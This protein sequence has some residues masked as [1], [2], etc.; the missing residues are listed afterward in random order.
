MLVDDNQTDNY[1]H[2]REIKKTKLAITI[3][4]KSSGLEALEYLKSDKENKTM[5]P[6]LIFL[7]INMP[8][9]NGWEFLQEYAL[10]DEEWKSDVTIIILTTSANPEYITKAKSLKIVTDYITK[11]LTKEILEDINNRYFIE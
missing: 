5:D 2:I 6:D 8:C 7:D 10:L 9:M 3:I 4:E 11:P 1:F